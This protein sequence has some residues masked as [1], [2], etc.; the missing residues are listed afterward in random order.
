MPFY[1]RCALLGAVTSKME[2][3]ASPARPLSQSGDLL[4]LDQPPRAAEQRAVLPVLHSKRRL[5]ARQGCTRRF[6][7]ALRLSGAGLRVPF[8]ARSQAVLIGV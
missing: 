3:P 4:P 6:L 7:S 1:L 2:I 8:W 5:G